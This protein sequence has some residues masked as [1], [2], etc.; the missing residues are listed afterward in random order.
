MVDWTDRMM[1]DEKVAEMVDMMVEKMVYMTAGLKDVKMVEKTV[2][3][4]GHN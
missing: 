4:K 3:Q 1:V 2:G